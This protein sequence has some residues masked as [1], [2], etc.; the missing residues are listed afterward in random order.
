MKLRHRFQTR[1][2][3]HLYGTIFFF[4]LNCPHQ[5]SDFD[6]ISP[7]YQMF[8]TDAELGKDALLFRDQSVSTPDHAR[9]W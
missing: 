7:Y 6:Y 8:T 2:L 5:F 4:F 1:Q 3:R 9:C